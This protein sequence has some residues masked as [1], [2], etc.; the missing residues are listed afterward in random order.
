MH[1]RKLEP[2]IDSGTGH[3]TAAHVRAE[4]TLA[5]A[6]ALQWAT[7]RAWQV[8]AWLLPLLCLAAFGWS[9]FGWVDVVA[10]ATGRTVPSGQ[11][12]HVQAAEQARVRRIHVREG[13]AVAAGQLLVEFEDEAA[14]AD[15]ARFDEQMLALQLDRMRLEALIAGR[16][17]DQGA[18]EI[19]QLLARRIAPALLELHHRRVLEERIAITT[20]LSGL[21]AEIRESMANAR[22]VA[23]EI[24]ELEQ[25]LP[26]VEENAHAYGTLAARGTVARVE[27]L[28]L[29]RER[30]ATDNRLTAARARGEALAASLQAHAA[31]RQA[32]ITQHRQRWLAELADVEGRLAATEEDLAKARARHTLR[33]VEAPVAGSVQQLVLHTAGAVV[34]PAQVL[35]IIVPRDTP[36]EIEARIENRDIGFVHPGQAAI[37]KFETWDF[38]RF[39]HVSGKVSAVSPDAI[40]GYKE[41]PWYL[42]RIRLPAQPRSNL[43]RVLAVRPGMLVR[44]EVRLGRRRLLDFLL[45]PL[46]RYRDESARER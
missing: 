20:V 12:K 17:Q 41:P 39:G 14:T 10:I 28:A 43:G 46:Q 37:V 22:V 30:I 23:S 4:N 45:S 13:Q 29:E 35:M 16:W 8:T 9:W 40:M 6:A 26:L 33:R 1:E 11:V 25:T 3:D 5:D 15:M 2:H 7:P 24:A 38:T 31:R 18:L 21:E 42:A 32:S 44:V 27:W 34:A 36:L 19:P